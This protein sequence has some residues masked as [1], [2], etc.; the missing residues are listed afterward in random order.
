MSYSAHIFKK[1]AATSR[2]LVKYLNHFLVVLEVNN[3]KTISVFGLFIIFIISI[4][5]V[6]GTMLALSLI[7][8]PM[9]IPTSRDEEDLDDL[10][11]DDFFYL[12]ERGVDFIFI[13]MLIHLGRK[14]YLR[15]FIREQ[16][17]AW[18]NGSLLFLIIHVTTFFG[19]SLCCTHLSDITLTIAANIIQTFTFKYGKL[20]YFLFTDQTLN[21][22][23]I[24][25]CAY[26]HYI[27][28]FACLL[29]GFVHANTMHYDY[30]DMSLDPCYPRSMEWY[31]C[32]FELEIDRF[33][34]FVI[35][36]N[37]IC[38]FFVYE[39]IESTSYEVFMWGDIGMSSDVRFYGVAPHWYFRAYMGWLLLCPHHYI[40]VFGLVLLMLSVYFQPN[41]RT[42]S[43]RYLLTKNT[44]FYIL[45]IIFFSIFVLC[46]LYTFSMLP[47][48]RFYN[49]INGNFGLMFS[50][51]YI[52]SYLIFDFLHYPRLLSYIFS[53][54]DRTYIYFSDYRYFYYQFKFKIINIY[55]SFKD[56]FK[57]K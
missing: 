39:A 40:G 10:Y 34:I 52:F 57:F 30:K 28:G 46:V 13:S 45:H 16:E 5:C 36:L 42:T 8:D 29:L 7:C 22:D 50:Y 51:L 17:T 11:T 32:I 56:L 44:D 14:I 41:L 33:F 24:I 25:R 23:T 27:L 19:L 48:G 26:M 49:Q 3:V 54:S 12:H 2:L 37:I 1:L 4:Q 9:L 6:T 20:Y 53:D 31:K 38:L 21:C 47:Y 15:S 43:C 18:K 55:N 35:W